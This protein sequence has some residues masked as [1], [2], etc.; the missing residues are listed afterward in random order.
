MSCVFL[1]IPPS[2]LCHSSSH[3][4][5]VF[6]SLLV[7]HITPVW[8]PWKPQSLWKLLPHINYPPVRLKCP[9]GEI[10]YILKLNL[11]ARRELH[12]SKMFHSDPSH[13]LLV[14]ALPAFLPAELCEK[15]KLQDQ[16][17]APRCTVPSSAASWWCDFLTRASPNPRTPCEPAR[18]RRWRW[19][20]VNTFVRGEARD[21]ACWS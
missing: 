2:F 12:N 14:L 19:A 8:M 16:C 4:H 6:Y 15:K 20:W 10:D 7:A 1:D 13:L 21:T 5:G 3:S 9:K 17:C 11:F 18:R